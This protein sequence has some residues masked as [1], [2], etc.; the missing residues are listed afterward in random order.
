MSNATK[1][2]AKQEQQ[3]QNRI[4]ALVAMP[5]HSVKV[6]WDRVVIR[7]QGLNFKIDTMHSRWRDPMTVARALMPAI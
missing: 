7:G 2:T 6:L 1:N 4:D 5:D 3:E